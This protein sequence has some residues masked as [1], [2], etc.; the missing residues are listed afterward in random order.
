MVD[1]ADRRA[2]TPSTVVVRQLDAPFTTMTGTADEALRIA[3]NAGRYEVSVTVPSYRSVTDTIA[4][5]NR[6]SDG[7]EVIYQQATT[8]ALTR[9]P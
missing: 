6:Q 7:C 9:L 8:I 2:L 1:A 4:V 3:V 5:A